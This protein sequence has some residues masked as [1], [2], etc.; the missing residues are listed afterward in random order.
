MNIQFPAETDPEQAVHDQR[1][2]ALQ[3]ADHFG[4]A[5]FRIVHEDRFRLARGEMRQHGAGVIAI[6]TTAGEN[7]D[8][9]PTPGQPQSTSREMFQRRRR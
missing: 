6:M 9:I 8:R 3:R 1:R 4:N 7:Q 2:P 5:S